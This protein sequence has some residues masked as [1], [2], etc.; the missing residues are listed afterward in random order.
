MREDV[1]PN[2]A[3][4]AIHAPDQLSVMLLLMGPADSVLGHAS[5]K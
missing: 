2:A 5:L 3:I 4:L 1:V